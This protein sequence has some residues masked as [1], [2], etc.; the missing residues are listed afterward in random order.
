M[1]ELDAPIIVG[2][3]SNQ[4]PAQAPTVPRI[5]QQSKPWVTIAAIAICVLIFVG[6]NSEKANSWDAFSKWGYLPA[7]RIWS[8]AY[9][10][11]ITNGFVHIAPWHLAFNMY[12]LW[13]L[14]G[15]ME[16]TIGWW[17]YLLFVIAA[18]FV[19]SAGEVAISGVNGIGASGFVYAIFGF[20]WIA[21]DRF[22]S[23]RA[24]LTLQLIKGF[25]VW[26]VGC[27]V[28]TYLDILQVANAAHFFGLLFGVLVAYAVVA[29]RWQ[30]AARGG[31]AALIACSIVPIFWCPWS[32]EWLS[33]KAYEA[34]A[35]RDIF[36]AMDLYSRILRSDANNAWA[37]YNRGLIYDELGQ[38]D[39]AHADW[40]DANRLDSSYKE[41]K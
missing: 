7:A 18:T 32:T 37:H 5:K 26:L 27:I 20:M 23:F 29:S 28:A 35:A 15:R 1:D 24:I 30:L 8:G 4:S 41:P 22:S 6:I 17:R 3:S 33:H 13:F 31:V 40:N 12:W 38:D 11:L 10:G 21:R 19:S 25:L 9:W 16:L 34:H 36:R 39:E 2:N 14:G